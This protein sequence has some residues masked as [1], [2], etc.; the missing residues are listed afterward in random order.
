LRHAYDVALVIADGHAEDGVRLVA[1]FQIDFAVEARIL[2][3]LL[4]VNHLLCLRHHS[5]DSNAKGNDNLL[6]TGPSHRVLEC[7][8]QTRFKLESIKGKTLCQESYQKS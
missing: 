4:D 6:G 8:N 1:C 7:C 2:V 3:G 5:R